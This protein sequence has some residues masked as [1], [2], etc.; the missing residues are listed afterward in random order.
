MRKAGVFLLMGFVFLGVFPLRL[1]AQTNTG[2]VEGRVMDESRH[3]LA[4]ATVTL[5]YPD[6]YERRKVTDSGGFFR[7]LSVPP[8]MGYRLRV[9][10]PGFITGEWTL[11]VNT[12][13]SRYIEALV[14]PGGTGEIVVQGPVPGLD[15]RHPTVAAGLSREQL[16]SL[17]TARDPWSVLELAPGVTVRETN[18]GGSR[19]ARQAYFYG[20]GEARNNAHWYVDGVMMTDPVERGAVMKQYD[21]D[22]LEEVQV[23]TG[24]AEVDVFTGGVTVNLVT[25]RGSN[26]SHGALRAL[27]ADDRLQSENIQGIPLVSPE[28]RGNRIDHLADYGAYISGPLYR[29]RAWFWLGYGV[30]DSDVLVPTA[31]ADARE[32]ATIRDLNLKLNARAGRHRLEFLASLGYQSFDQ[33][34]VGFQRSPAAAWKEKNRTPIWK[35]QDEWKLRDGVLLMLKYGT[36]LGHTIE[37]TPIGGRDGPAVLDLATGI[38][39]RSYQ[40]QKQ[41][42]IVHHWVIQSDMFL[43]G[44]WAAQ[45]EIKLGAEFRIASA[46]SESSWG[47]GMTIAYEDRRDPAQGGEV[48]YY[49][50]G[51]VRPYVNH[52]T[53][54]VQDRLLLSRWTLLAGLRYDLQFSGLRRSQVPG[55]SRLPA[56]LPPGEESGGALSFRWH[57]FSP[58]VGIT[59]DALGDGRLF[60]KAG[61]ALYP[62]TLDTRQARELTPTTLKEIAFPWLGDGNGNGIPDDEEVDYAHPIFWNHE[63]GNPNRVVNAIDPNFGSPLTSEVTLGFD[64][65]SRAD[66]IL[67]A[68]LFY[69]RNFHRKENFPYDP[70]GKFTLED[71]YNCWEPVGNLPPEQGGWP[72]YA[73]TL[74]KPAGEI[75]VNQPGY[76]REYWGAEIRARREV[77]RNWTFFGSAT[78]ERYTHHY[79]SRRA[80]MDPTNIAQKDGATVAFGGANARWT[81]KFGGLARLPYGFRAAV[82]VTARD[83]FPFLARYQVTRPSH[84]WGRKVKVYTVKPGELRLPALI[85]ANLHLDR[86]FPLGP[87]TFI[88][89]VDVFNAFNAHTILKKETRA[90]RPDQFGRATEVLSPRVLRVGFRYRF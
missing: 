44:P 59:F 24:T 40:W 1:E 84:G 61:A 16:E 89:G 74:D 29:D 62:A 12:G 80:Y 68:T 43:S 58:R 57:T 22:A 69:R 31:G 73:C 48:H 38:W 39:D 81:V 54:Y 30:L 65:Q 50:T 20:R 75:W 32:S 41:S 56:W 67:S 87:G 33:A 49:R 85:V 47:N 76:Y 63:P 42:R 86:A 6:G 88:L 46:R 35:L 14:K 90:D 45:H 77:S 37:R 52:W 70:D 71:Y 51:L 5:R 28:S 26:R 21:F 2:V 19:A 53:A 7:F 79:T 13:E 17:P 10:I 27:I 34:G 36:T 60:L 3:P 78:W 83:G 18:I 8:G 23:V 64:W 4:G 55:N 66:W 15:T 82:T 72:Y 9:E 25:K 11:R